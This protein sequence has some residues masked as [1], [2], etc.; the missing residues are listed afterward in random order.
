MGPSFRTCPRDVGTAIP[1]SNLHTW[2]SRSPKPVIGLVS[3]DHS[4]EKLESEVARL[5]LQVRKLR[6]ILRL[7]IVLLRLP[8]FSLEL[9]RLP[10][11]KNKQ[12]L[13]QE[14]NRACTLFPLRKVL[15]MI[16]LSPSRYHAW[17][18]RSPSG[19][20]DIPSC[21]K[22]KPS[23]LTSNEVAVIREMINT[24]QTDPTKSPVQSCSQHGDGLEEL[25]PADR[26][27]ATVAPRRRI[28]LAT[29]VPLDASQQTNGTA[30]RVPTARGLLLAGQ[31][32]THCTAELP[33]GYR[34]R[35]CQGGRRG[36]GD[37]GG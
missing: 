32:T 12:R 27:D 14:V 28:R 17:V 20:T 37:S 2:K 5:T 36:E 9:S 1:R 19:L 33:A 22:S 21:P 23:Q 11:G 13:L 25:E 29:I 8:G 26:N 30:A 18:R 16:R 35:F 15:A 34:R 4:I 3:S 10:E 24:S 31:F 6:C 7:L